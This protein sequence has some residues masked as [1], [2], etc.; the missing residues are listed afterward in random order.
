MENKCTLKLKVFLWLLLMDRLNSK[1]LLQRKHF[2]T[3]G[4]DRCVTCNSLTT[5][6]SFH[7]FFT[8]SFA[9]Q[10][11]H[12][13][14]IDGNFHRTFMDMIIEAKENFQFP[15]F[16]ETFAICCWNIWSRRNDFIFNNVP[17]NF[18]RWRSDFKEEF[19]L[20]MRRVKKSE[21]TLWQSWIQPF[22]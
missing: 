3:Q 12:N 15:F 20:H 18:Q 21:Q 4:N 1:D 10:C 2:N 14:G 16:M 9:Q 8:C 17:V 6:D 5:E 13:I 22:D 11:W 19:T 7:L